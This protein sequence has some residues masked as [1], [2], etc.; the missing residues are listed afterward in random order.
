MNRSRAGMVSFVETCTLALW[1]G[2]ALFFAAVV[3]PAAFDVL[4]GPTLAGAL[5]GR[6]LPTLFVTGI[7]VALLILAL[8]I[9]APRRGGRLRATGAG[10]M[11]IACAIAQFVIGGEI[12]RLRSGAGS[13]I[14]V[15]SRDD[16]RRVAFGRLHALSVAALGAAMVAAAT[17]AVAGARQ[18]VRS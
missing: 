14:G 5:V 8:E 1:L 15:L 12:D 4:P 7:V 3:A 16:P 17:A 9:R 11:L 10:V 6:V 13:P 18:P 2:A